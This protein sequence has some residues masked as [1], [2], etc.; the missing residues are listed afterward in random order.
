NFTQSSVDITLGLGRLYGF[1]VRCLFET[2]DITDISTMQEISP[3]I[4]ANTAENTSTTLTDA[5]DN[6]TYTVK[7][8]NGDVWMTQNLRFTSTSVPTA[9]SNV[10]ADKTLTYYSLDS[11]SA[12]SFGAYSGHCDDTNGYNY[13]CI[14]DSGSADT[15]VWYNYYAATA[16]TISTD[17]NDAT[18]SQDICP[19]NWHLPTGPNTTSGT[20]INRLVGNT[21]SGWQEA[22]ASLT[23]FDGVSGGYYGGNG[24]LF[25]A[26]RGYWWSATAYDTTLRYALD[27]NSDDGTFRGSSYNYGYIGFSIRCITNA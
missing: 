8:I 10:T 7:K 5:R 6:N 22:T 9:T 19:K 2:R 18:A 26:E 27:Y 20:D 12:G 25:N 13:A 4:A 14:Y 23:T 15:G 17:S 11:S 21:T 16:G 3:A 24:S 1:S